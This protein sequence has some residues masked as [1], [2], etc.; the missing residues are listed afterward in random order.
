MKRKL[1]LGL[2]AVS[3]LLEGYLTAIAFISPE[4]VV[5][6][7]GIT[8]DASLAFPTFILAWFLLL[9][10]IL[11]A[12]IIY[13]V[14]ENKAGYKPILVIL[15]IWWIGIGIGIY[16]FQGVYDNLLTDSLKGALLLIL[17]PKK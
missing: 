7:L 1:L 12:Y 11:I 6:Q 2:L 9:V 17:L 5:K 8:Y 16:F 3:F 10:T 4:K 14:W 13:A 15:S